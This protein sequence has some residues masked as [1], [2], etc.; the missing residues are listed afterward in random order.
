MTTIESDIVAGDDLLWLRGNVYDSL[1][2]IGKDGYLFCFSEKI[3]IDR[4][5]N[6]TLICENVYVGVWLKCDLSV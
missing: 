5:S 3:L 6:E 4:F 2:L 1:G